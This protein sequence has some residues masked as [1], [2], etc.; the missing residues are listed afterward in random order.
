MLLI[1]LVVIGIL[2]M[3]ASERTLEG[4]ERSKIGR[5]R[6]DNENVKGAVD[7]TSCEVDPETG[8]CCIVTIE[9]VTTVQKEPILGCTHKST[10]QCHYMYATQFKPTVQEVCVEGFEKK[11]QITFKQQ[12]SRRD[13]W[14][15]VHL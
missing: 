5:L 15:W 9:Q 11:C 1:K 13:M 8:F 4:K 3:V 6:R 2:G 7:F 10:E 12:A 14:S